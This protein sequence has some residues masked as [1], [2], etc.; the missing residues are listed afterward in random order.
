M[1][2]KNII[3][4]NKINTYARCVWKKTENDEMEQKWDEDKKWVGVRN[5]QNA[6]KFCLR[7]L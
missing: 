7:I 3:C 2:S 1:R 5:D 6:D 4:M